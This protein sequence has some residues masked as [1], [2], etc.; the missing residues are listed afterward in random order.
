MTD[1]EHQRDALTAKPSTSDADHGPV[2]TPF[3]RTRVARAFANR[4]VKYPLAAILVALVITATTLLTLGFTTQPVLLVPTIRR[5]AAW[6][7]IKWTATGTTV[8]PVYPWRMNV[9]IYNPN[10]FPM[11]L[12]DLDMTAM[13]AGPD[14]FPVLFGT[15][16]VAT[17]SNGTDR[18][19]RI[20]AH[21]T[22]WSFAF[23][24]LKWDLADDAQ[25][26][27][28]GALLVLCGVSYY[29]LPRGVQPP[30]DMRG[31]LILPGTRGPATTVWR[32]R[33]QKVTGLLGVDVTPVEGEVEWAYSWRQSWWTGVVGKQS[34]DI[35]AVVCPDYRSVVAEHVA[36]LAN[37]TLQVCEATGMCRG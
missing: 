10:L 24:D 37:V 29:D 33:A 22:G 2:C 9:A 6:N 19:I 13:F 7:P 11:T 15:A 25:A 4:R 18:S 35:T 34:E 14:G 30:L 3:S 1:V 8:A 27:A 17:G 20:P 26:R 21:E 23:L 12:H 36:M 28:L 5:P 31:G 32:A 16:H